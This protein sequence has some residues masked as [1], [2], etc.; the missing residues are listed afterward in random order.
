MTEEHRCK[1]CS[2]L[3]SNKNNLVF[4]ID[5]T[6]KCLELQGKDTSCRCSFCNKSFSSIRQLNFHKKHD[7]N[8]LKLQGRDKKIYK[9]DSCL[10]EYSSEKCFITHTKKCIPKNYNHTY[11]TVKLKESEDI[12]NKLTDDIKQL[13]GSKKELETQLEILL[14]LIKIKL[15]KEKLHLLNEINID[16]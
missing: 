13:E 11:Y 16:F 1:F 4:H 7:I 5:N 8:C 10:K 12:I 9:C 14:K 2:K 6:K 3:F 15:R